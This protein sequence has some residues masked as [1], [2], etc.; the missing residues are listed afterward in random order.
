MRYLVGLDI[1]GTKCAVT[2]GAENAGEIEIL[3]DLE[4][5]RSIRLA[6]LLPDF[7]GKARY[8]G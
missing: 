6:Q 5:E 8:L 1:G 3:L 2:L 7:W 4:S